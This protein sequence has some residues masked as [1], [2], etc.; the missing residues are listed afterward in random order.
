MRARLEELDFQPTPI[1]EVSLR[2][3][4]D[5]R[6]GDDVFEVKLGEEYLMSSLFVV[7][8][9]ELSRL[10]LGRLAG[11]ALDVA[12]GGLGLGYTAA[13]ALADPRVGELVVV[14]ALAPV[15]DW[16]R[17]GLVP[18][19]PVLTADPRCRLVHGD[20]FALSDGAGF[21]PDRPDRVFDAVVVDIDHSPAHLLADGSAGFYSPAGT[22]RLARHL[23][24]GGVYALWSNDP[25]DAGYLDVLAGVFVDVAAEVVTFPNPLQ[26]RDATNTVYVA[27]RPG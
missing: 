9:E 12:V 14:D 18:V 27:T 7:A 13:A 16:H 3:R 25:P 6:T 24:P 5:P 20:F 8:E 26:G 21:D 23:R 22:A 11:E 2:R 19:G 10:A 15:I 4:T 1:G 17:R